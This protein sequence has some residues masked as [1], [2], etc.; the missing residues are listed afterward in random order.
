[1]S[2]DGDRDLD[3]KLPEKRALAIC[4]D[5]ERETFNFQIDL[6]EKPMTQRGILSIVT[7]IY[8]PLGFVTPF[9]LKGKRLLQLLCQDGIGWDERVDDSII[10]EWLIWEKSLKD[11]GGHKINSCFKP[12]GFGKT[13]EFWLHHF[14][15]ASEEGYGQVSYLRMVN[16]DESIHY[17]FLAGKARVTPKKFILIPHL[18]LVAPVLSVKGTNFLKKKFQIVKLHLGI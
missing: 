8:D 4:W 15:D 2:R 14:P 17:C 16:T 11:M 5:I 7:S 6:K 3:G 13:K 12:S 18:E 10:N 1:M 9:I